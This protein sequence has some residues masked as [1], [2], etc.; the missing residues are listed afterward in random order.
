MSEG[1]ELKRLALATAHH[2]AA[3]SVTCE[4]SLLQI[5]GKYQTSACRLHQD[6]VEIRMHIQRLVGGYGPG[7]GGPDHR[8]DRAV[9]QPI[10]AKGFGKFFAL[11]FLQWETDVDGDGFLVLVLDLRLGQR[12]TAIEAPVD[13]LQAAVKIS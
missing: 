2:L 3:E 11:A 7:R 4:T 6:I 12:R 1:D 8:I 10:Q 5:G 9:G 13:R